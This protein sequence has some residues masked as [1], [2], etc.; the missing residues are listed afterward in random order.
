M[1]PTASMR[2][3]APN[4]RYGTHKPAASISRSRRSGRMSQTAASSASTRSRQLPAAAAGK[5][6]L[7]VMDGR[8]ESL[9]QLVTTYNA[10]AVTTGTNQHPAGT[11]HSVAANSHNNLVFV[12]LGANNAFLS[13]DA[14]QNCL[15]GCV[16]VFGHPDEQN[17]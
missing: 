5:T 13:P 17:Q 3:M 15:T 7:D 8:D 12:P 9:L 10:P 4:S 16:A 2:R 1:R 14:K 6:P 11:A